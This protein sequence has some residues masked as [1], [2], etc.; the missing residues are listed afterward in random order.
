MFSFLKL[1]SVQTAVFKTDLFDLNTKR[2]NFSY[3]NPETKI[4]K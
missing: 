1:Q 2:S 3:I 4:L